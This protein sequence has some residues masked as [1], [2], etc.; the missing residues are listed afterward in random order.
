MRK[1]IFIAKVTQN[2]N[3]LKNIWGNSKNPK[4]PNHHRVGLTTH[5]YRVITY[6]KT[7]VAIPT[8]SAFFSTE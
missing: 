7:S 4:S 1:L 5:R 8:Y 2:K 3:F 6:A